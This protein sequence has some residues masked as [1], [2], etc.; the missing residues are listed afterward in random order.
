MVFDGKLYQSSRELTFITNETKS[1]KRTEDT[2][3]NSYMDIV[4]N[5]M[6][7]QMLAKARIKRFGETVIDT[8]FK[9][10]KN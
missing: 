6:F 7:T 10:F 5:V 2:F 9:D 3:K 1:I 8:I 4:Y